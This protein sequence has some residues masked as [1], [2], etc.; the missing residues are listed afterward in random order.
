MYKRHPDVKRD[1]WLCMPDAWRLAFVIYLCLP[2]ARLRLLAFAVDEN[3]LS[4]D[5]CL[6]RFASSAFPFR[7]QPAFFLKCVSSL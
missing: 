7:L 4:S 1:G 2:R 3:A 6:M 5:C